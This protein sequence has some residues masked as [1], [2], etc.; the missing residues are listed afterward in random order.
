M[1]DRYLELSF[2]EE[3]IASGVVRELAVLLMSPLIPHVHHPLHARHA[4]FHIQQVARLL[5]QAQGWSAGVF[6]HAHSVVPLSVAC[7][8][9]RL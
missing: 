5:G 4:L 8:R 6:Y 3:L 2:G 7:F 1:S 9:V